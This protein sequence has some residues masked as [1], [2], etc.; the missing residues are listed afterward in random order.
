MILQKSSLKHLSRAVSSTSPRILLARR[1]IASYNLRNIQSTWPKLKEEER[2]QIIDYL[3]ARQ[4]EPW[5]GLNQDEK[6]A[7]VYISYGPWGPRMTTPEQAQS[8]STRIIGTLTG[9]ILMIAVGLT[10][11][12]YV[13]DEEKL[14]ELNR[15]EQANPEL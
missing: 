14:E 7:C 11:V 4:E 5:R 15:Y 10:L 9:S 1:S 12:N 13:A 3:A 6:K 2:D 8:I